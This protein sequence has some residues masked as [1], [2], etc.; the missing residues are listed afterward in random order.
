MQ[1]LLAIEEAETKLAEVPAL[2]RRY[3]ERD[4]EFVSAVKSWLKDTEDTLGRYG[5]PVA[6]EI[7]ASRGELIAC[8]RG[9]RDGPAGAGPR[10][11]AYREGR[12]AEVL[13]HATGTVLSA[14]QQRR[15]QLDEAERVMMQIVAVA[16]RLGLVPAE[17]GQGHTAYLQAVL[18][19]IADRPELSSLV[20]HVTGLLGKADVLIV[21]DRSISRVRG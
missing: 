3:D 18:Q 15:G 5:M 6:S 13:K 21:L 2:V 1:H 8:E 20:V 12:A 19:A 16:D 11:R 17:S 10:G 4:P 14:I 9:H 7:A